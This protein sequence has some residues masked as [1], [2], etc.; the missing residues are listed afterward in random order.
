MNLKNTFSQLSQALPTAHFSSHSCVTPLLQCSCLVPRVTVADPALF[1][2][3]LSE[4]G[5][6]CIRSVLQFYVSL[7]HSCVTI[8]VTTALQFV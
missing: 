6:D 2:Q 4:S 8:C 1:L 5:S 7:F 3:L